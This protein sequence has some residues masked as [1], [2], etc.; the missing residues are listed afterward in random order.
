MTIVPVIDL[1]ADDDVV[2]IE[3]DR[4]CREVGFFQIVGHG[5]DRALIDTT[6]STV[7]AF[8]DLPLEDR[9]AAAR[10]R[11]DYPFAYVPMAGE[12]LSNSLGNGGQPDLKET[13][14]MGPVRRPPGGPG[15]PDEEVL[16][17][18][19]LWPPAM[20]SLRPA[21]EAY[22]EAMEQLAARLLR[23]SAV[24]LGLAPDFF[25]SRID[26]G[27]NALRALNY[28]DQATAPPPGQLRAGAHTDYG[29]ITILR[30]DDAP[31]GLEVL[32]H[33]SGM[34]IAVPSIADAFVINV[35]DMLAQWTND[36]W[37]ST[38]HRVVNPPC[39]A[40]ARRQSMAFFHNANFHC[41]VACLPTCT[42]PEN[43]PRYAPVLAGPHLVAKF[44]RTG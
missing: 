29:T 30:Q 16:F 3:I 28:P 12:T 32:D 43:P 1:S 10:P 35:G 33:L 21:L 23:L 36:R 18:P 2:A 9:L 15:G 34:W 13:F 44:R 37:R 26:V 27:T 25:V 39:N 8:F 22:F 17:S 7:R 20:P 11:P 38:L 14:N 40:G 31:G 5:I 42:S 41:E 4:V 6:W 19:T 24:G